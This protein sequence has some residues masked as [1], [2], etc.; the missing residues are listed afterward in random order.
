MASVIRNTKGKAI[1]AA[2]TLAAADDLDGAGTIL[3]VPKGARVIIVQIN[4]GTLGTAGVDVIEISA[5][6]GAAFVADPTL[7]ASSAADQGGTAVAS[8]ALNAAGVE[9][10]GAAA[11]KAGPYATD[12]NMRCARLTGTGGGTT[13]VTGAP[14]VLAFLIKGRN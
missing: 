3:F 8:A 10:T 4:N 13:W 2:T 6:P 14:S 5:P 1:P 12:V 11:W 9:P 7:L